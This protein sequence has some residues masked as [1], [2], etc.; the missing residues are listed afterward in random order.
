MAPHKL[1]RALIEEKNEKGETLTPEEVDLLF[2]GIGERIGNLKDVE[3]FLKDYENPNKNPLIGDIVDEGFSM[4]AMGKELIEQEIKLRTEYRD[5]KI[6]MQKNG[7]ADGDDEYNLAQGDHEDKMETL[8]LKIAHEDGMLFATLLFLGVDRYAN[9]I[10]NV[11][12]TTITN[13]R[14]IMDI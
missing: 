11:I 13:D 5:Q 7:I 9:A 4:V 8:S 14:S 10:E 6:E 2:Y 3:Q 12:L 1:D